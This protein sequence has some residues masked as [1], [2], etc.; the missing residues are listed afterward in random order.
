MGTTRAKSLLALIGSQRI[1]KTL[2]ERPVTR[3]VARMAIT[4]L[5]VSRPLMLPATASGLAAS[6]RCSLR[7]SLRAC[8]ALL[9]PNQDSTCASCKLAAC[10]H[11]R[12]D[13]MPSR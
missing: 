13:P 10:H 9:D 12:F 2:R 7:S 6:G 5:Y 11:S 8:S 4:S 3:E 1:V